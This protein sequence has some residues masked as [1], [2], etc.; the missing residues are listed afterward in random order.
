MSLRYGNLHNYAEH[1]YTN[2]NTNLLILEIYTEFINLKHFLR[3]RAKPTFS[4]EYKKLVIRRA[5]G[6][7][8]RMNYILHL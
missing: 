3:D 7:L 8:D 1:R 4:V 2:V 5:L 6:T